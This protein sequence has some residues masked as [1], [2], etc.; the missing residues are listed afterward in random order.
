[1]EMQE[2]ISASC[3][4]L[5]DPRQRDD[6]LGLAEATS[7]SYWSPP[8]GSTK[9]TVEEIG[10]R[11]MQT[12]A[13]GPRCV[14]TQNARQ[15]FHRSIFALI[16]ASASRTANRSQEDENEADLDATE[17][18]WRATVKSMSRSYGGL[19]LRTGCKVRNFPVTTGIESQPGLEDGRS[20]S[21]R[22]MDIAYRWR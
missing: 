14:E 3:L 17:R 10:H 12:E 15:P 1:M 9:T 2:A 22:S 8:G 19:H 5:P 11:S 6:R 21:S 4:S 7:A 20:R 18:R 16:H 13:L